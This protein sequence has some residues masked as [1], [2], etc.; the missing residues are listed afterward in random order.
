[1]YNETSTLAFFRRILN[2]VGVILVLVA[3][4]LFHGERFDGYY[5]ILGIIAFFLS[6]HLFDDLA[7]IRPCGARHLWSG[8]GSLLI[9]WGLTVG[10]LLFLAYLT[11]LDYLFDRQTILHWFMA[12]PFVLFLGH[13]CLRWYVHRIHLHGQ[14]RRAVIVG[15]NEAGLR[16]RGRLENNECLLTDCLGFFDDRREDRLS[17]A[18]REHYLGHSSNLAEYAMRERVDII[19]ITL[20]I[21]QRERIS[22]LLMALKDTTASIYLVPDIFTYDLIQARIDQMGGIPVIAILE[23]PFTS[24]NALNKRME[25]IVLSLLILVLISPVMLLIALAVKLSSHGPVIFSQRRYGLNGEEIIVYKFRSMR[26]MEDGDHVPQATR[27]DER[28]TRL[29]RFLRKTSLDELPQF[30]NVLQGRMSIVG[31]RPHAVAHNELYR[32]LI[33]GYM[34]RHKVK[35]GITGW[36]Q[37]NGLRGETESLDKMAARIQY[38]LDYIRNWSLSLDLHIILKT[39]WL[40]FKDAHAY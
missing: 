21:S 3:S 35:P 40:V 28:T 1:M 6:S 22:A 27:D 2:P 12:T 11:R 33:S 15:G 36:A 9:A 10:A 26:V 14:A 13:M 23:T 16:L 38:D 32:K 34:L 7:I 5:V 31:P 25:D 19:Y 4:M 30:V 8:L 24:I 37:V 18:V 20:P 39:V 29:G 17:G